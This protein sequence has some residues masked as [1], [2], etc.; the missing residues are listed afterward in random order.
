[1]ITPPVLPRITG[2]LDGGLGRG[3]LCGM[4]TLGPSASRSPTA[5]EVA[6][7]RRLFGG[8]ISYDQRL[9]DG[10]GMN[11]AAGI[12]IGIG[13]A[14]GI[15]LGNTIYFNPAQY[16]DDFS[17]STRGGQGLLAHEYTHIWQYQTH[18]AT[19]VVVAVNSLSMQHKGLDPYDIRAVGADSDFAALG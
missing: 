5:G 16:E 18:R 10:A 17:L 4:W 7:L 1:R 15:T 9:V 19:P 6:L 13:R 11:P 8:S 14:Q 3:Q 12:A 2:R